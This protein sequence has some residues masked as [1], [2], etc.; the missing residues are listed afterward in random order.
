M[1]PYEVAAVLVG[2]SAVALMS[3]L[4]FPLAIAASLIATLLAL[5]IGALWRMLIWPQIVGRYYSPYKMRYA[6]RPFGGAHVRNEELRRDA[7]VPLGRSTLHVRIRPKAPTTIKDFNVRLAVNRRPLPDDLPD[8]LPPAIALITEVRA[9]AHPAF[10]AR[11]DAANPERGRWM[12]FNPELR[13]KRNQPIDLEIDIKANR[14]HK[15]FYISF[16][17]TERQIG[18]LRIGIDPDQPPN[19]VNL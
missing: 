13:C 8:D 6:T 9:Y 4:T 3:G 11:T 15:G 2:S 1:R 5:T 17:D 18:R 19:T 7:L 16:R 14:P 10:V 12:F